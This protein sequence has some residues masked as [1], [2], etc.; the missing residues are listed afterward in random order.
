MQWTWRFWRKHFCKI[1][2]SHNSF[3]EDLGLLE[4]EALSLGNWLLMFGRN[5]TASYPRWLNPLSIWICIWILMKS[6]D[7]L[8][9]QRVVVILLSFCV[10]V[11]EHSNIYVSIILEIY[12]CWPLLHWF[13]MKSSAGYAQS[14]KL[15][16]VSGSFTAIN[17]K[18]VNLYPENIVKSKN[19]EKY[20]GNEEWLD[21]MLVR[22]GNSHFGLIFFQRNLLLRKQNGTTPTFIQPHKYLETW[23]LRQEISQ[24]CWYNSTWLRSTT[25]CKAVI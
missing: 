9:M 5:G 15:I 23:I 6:Y 12:L 7:L 2:G 20:N 8:L 10:L 18:Y 21:Q 4:Y 22:W 3:S 17:R 24:K 13:D 16:I 14:Y 11:W 19:A 25:F 1:W